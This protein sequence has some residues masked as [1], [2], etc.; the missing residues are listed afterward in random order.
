[1]TYVESILKKIKKL[2]ENLNNL[3]DKIIQTEYDGNFSIGVISNM[4]ETDKMFSEL[5]KNLGRV[6]FLFNN[7]SSKNSVLKSE[8]IEINDYYEKYR[9]DIKKY[10]KNKK[11]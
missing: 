4:T 6:N 11:K 2:N 8:L 1:M 5:G 3:Y 7:I 9:L 10:E